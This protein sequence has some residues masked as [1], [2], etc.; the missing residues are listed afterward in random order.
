MSTVLTLPSMKQM[1][2]CINLLS[3]LTLCLLHGA[4]QAI[5][6]YG[7]CHSPRLLLRK[8]TRCL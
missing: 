6:P 7:T 2:R 4:A 8:E 5:Q 1:C 3:T